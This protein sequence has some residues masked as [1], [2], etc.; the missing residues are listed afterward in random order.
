M[1]IMDIGK[2]MVIAPETPWYVRALL[3]CAKWE[4]RIRAFFV[5]LW[6]SL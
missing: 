2:K 1:K 5:I 3:H 6:R 4:F